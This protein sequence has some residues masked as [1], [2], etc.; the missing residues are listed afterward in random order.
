MHSHHLAC[1]LQWLWNHINT[2]FAATPQD[3]YFSTDNQN[4]I[5]R[6]IL[7]LAYSITILQRPI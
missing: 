5:W 7:D 4:A 1:N 3:I 2:G 6:H